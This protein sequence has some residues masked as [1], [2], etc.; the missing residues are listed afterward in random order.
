MLT[1][2]QLKNLKQI[3]ELSDLS[4]TLY[5][6]FYEKFLSKILI[7][8]HLQDGKIINLKFKEYSIP[9]LLG[10]HHYDYKHQNK[11]FYKLVEQNSISILYYV[12]NPDSRIKKAFRDNKKRV[13]AFACIYSIL[14]DGS[15]IYF[16]D[17]VLQGKIEADYA[18]FELISEKGITIGARECLEDPEVQSPITILIASKNN[19][20]KHIINGDLVMIEK[21]EIFQVTD[22]KESILLET[23]NH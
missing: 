6:E 11:D 12:N 10:M 14:K 15:M 8:Y 19:P 9:H 18:W 16:P 13:C 2:E 17:G 1:I 23:I 22:E 3:P 21:T 20:H 4:L 7:R 5:K